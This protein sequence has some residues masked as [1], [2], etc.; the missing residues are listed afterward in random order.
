VVAAMLDLPLDLF[1]QQSDQSERAVEFERARR[2]AEILRPLCDSWRMAKPGPDGRA[3][4]RRRTDA[5]V[6]EGDEGPRL[7]AATR[8]P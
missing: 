2:R 5:G 7:R 4:A 8:Q 1:F 3:A 6:E